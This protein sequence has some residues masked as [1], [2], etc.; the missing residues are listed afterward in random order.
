MSEQIKEIQGRA[1]DNY[2]VGS[3]MEEAFC[4]AEDDVNFLL[5]RIAQL[6][7]ER[8]QAREWYARLC[9]SLKRCDPD[10]YYVPDS[11]VIFSP[12]A[13]SKEDTAGRHRM[14]CRVSAEDRIEALETELTALRKERDKW[15][16][17]HRDAAERLL[18]LG[19][20]HH[21]TKKKLV[22]LRK[23]RDALREALIPF[24]SLDITDLR[25]KPNDR[26]VYGRNATELTVGDFRR[27]AALSEEEVDQ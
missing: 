9:K 27:A 26:P 12:H 3:S 25:D 22:A 20:I 15:E 11:I 14:K 23:E 1:D 2:R 13:L 19:N 5:T 21:E 4:I 16:D 24:G 17:A 6:E 7:A 10:T 18:E 8:E